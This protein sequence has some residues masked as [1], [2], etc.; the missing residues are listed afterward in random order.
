MTQA[1]N[2]PNEP[3]VPPRWHFARPGP[4][5]RQRNSKL[6]EH[7]AGSGSD[8]AGDLAREGS[9]NAGDAARNGGP[10]RVRIGFGTLDAALVPPYAAGL[11][12]HAPEIAKQ[13]GLAAVAAVTAGQPLAYL[14][15]ED[16]NT[17]GLTGDPSVARRYDGDPPNAFHTFF[18]AE[19][20]TDKTDDRKQGSKGVGKV[21]FMAPSHARA[22][23]GLTTRFDDKKTLLFGTA[24]LHT[25]RLGAEHFD[26]DAWYGFA[27]ITGVDG[28]LPIAG[29]KAVE[30]FRQ[31]FKLARLPG[32]PGLSVVVPWLDTNEE[33]GVTPGRV[34]DAILRDHAWPILTSKLVVEVE[35]P[36]EP[37]TTID[38]AHFLAVLDAR[39]DDKLKAQ[40]RPMAKLAAW[41]I[42][43]P[44][45]APADRLGFHKAASP[46][47]NDPGLV[48]AEQRDNLRAA[49]A[50]GDPVAVRVPVRVRPKGRGETDKESWFD[51]F[52]QKDADSAA[53]AGPTVQFVRGG[54]LIS[55]MGRR[56]LGYRGLVLAE[57]P[58]IAGF[59]RASENP[60]HTKWNAK[61]I[62]DRYT[63]APATLAYV[64]ESVKGLAGLLADDPAEKDASIWA[65]ELSLPAGDLKL[66][67]PAGGAGGSGADR[68][69]KPKTSGPADKIPKVVKTRP[70]DVVVNADGFTV[71][72]S[73]VPFPNGLPARLELR[74]A[75]H[76]RGKDPLKRWVRDDFDLTD[77]TAFALP[78]SGCEVVERE[79]N[80][81]VLR[82]D[83]P[84]FEFNAA[85]FDTRR[86]LFCKP[87]LEKPVGGPAAEVE[88]ADDDDELVADGAAAE[89]GVL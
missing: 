66:P 33:D 86:E 71:K 75:Y 8:R 31:D 80:R 64:V 43:H 69:P 20:Q 29:A 54:L 5:Q 61:P 53:T 10:V 3:A 45:A 36:G 47:W 89:G 32:E 18:R 63:Y 25:H 30:Q 37:L 58:G 21:T 68:A 59:L 84:D 67:G 34:I 87:R 40:V 65:N 81:L 16:F 39:P 48:T 88:G 51:V 57:E 14:T 72:P 52:L 70:Y 56:V 13:K 79:P 17:T 38:A 78:A 28:V 49:L 76:V 44:P 27:G 26:G 83:S 74:L 50:A 24:V 12:E 9:Q 15:F 11:T 23:F 35:I 77:A 41:A 73:K 46:N 62:K 4:V 7:F 2:Q 22:V 42:A 82:I 85:G 6:D 19:G 60:S 1:G 55:G